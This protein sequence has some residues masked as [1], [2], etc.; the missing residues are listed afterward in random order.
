[1]QENNKGRETVSHPELVFITFL[2]LADTKWN[3]FERVTGSKESQV[4][5]GVMRQDDSEKLIQAIIKKINKVPTPLLMVSR[6][7]INHSSD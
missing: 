7:M 2:A 5:G 1:M 6:P 4:K 3:P